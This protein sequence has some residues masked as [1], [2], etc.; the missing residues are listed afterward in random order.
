LYGFWGVMEWVVII[1]NKINVYLL[2]HKI[3]LFY[4]MITSVLRLY[5]NVVWRDYR[6]LVGW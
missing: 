5:M 3:P 2:P 4:N 1:N 6:I